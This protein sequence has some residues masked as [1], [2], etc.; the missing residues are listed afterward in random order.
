MSAERG[1]PV[2][3]LVVVLSK[4]AGSGRLYSVP[5]MKWQAYSQGIGEDLQRPLARSPEVKAHTIATCA[6]GLIERV[7]RE[8][9]ADNE[10][11]NIQHDSKQ[12]L[13]TPIVPKQSKYEAG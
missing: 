5:A 3:K 7:R 10:A 8:L 1:D 13:T 12:L 4:S 2:K 9:E 11:G 6:N